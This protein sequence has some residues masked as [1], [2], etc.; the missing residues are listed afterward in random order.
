[1]NNFD[2]ESADKVLRTLY[3]LAPNEMKE[4]LLICDINEIPEDQRDIIYRYLDSREFF[5]VIGKV[6]N[7]D[8][9]IELSKI[10]VRFFAEGN[11]VDE[12]LKSFAHPAP[13]VS[14][15]YNI[16]GHASNFGN[17]NSAPVKNTSNHITIT[18][19]K[20]KWFHKFFHD[21][22]TQII[23]ALVVTGVVAFIAW[24]FN[25]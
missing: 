10:G 17:T 16:N 2:R 25:S 4:Y 11:L 23:S 9:Y 22:S 1:M 6:G 15:S 14:N 20:E 19:P 3:H 24:W 12:Y 13:S 18:E 21:T 5:K 7:G 8:R